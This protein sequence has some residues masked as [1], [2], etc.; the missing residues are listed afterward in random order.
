MPPDSETTLHLSMLLVS[1][2]VILLLFLELTV[3]SDMFV[4]EVILVFDV[5]ALDFLEF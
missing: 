5:A 1:D 3:F 2:L 4:F